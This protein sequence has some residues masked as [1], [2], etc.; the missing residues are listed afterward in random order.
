MKDKM[1]R[2]RLDREEQDARELNRKENAGEF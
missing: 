2:T 1:K